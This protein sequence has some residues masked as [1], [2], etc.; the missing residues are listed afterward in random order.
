MCDR[1]LLIRTLTILFGS[2]SSTK[3]RLRRLAIYIRC[4]H[5]QFDSSGSFGNIKRYSDHRTAFLSSFSALRTSELS[6]CSQCVYGTAQERQKLD[7]GLLN[8]ILCHHNLKILRF[9]HKSDTQKGNTLLVQINSVLIPLT[10]GDLRTII[11]GLPCL[12]ILEAASAE[13]NIVSFL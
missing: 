9:Y 5:K 4:I 8:A 10:I 6:C 3:H 2:L 1:V 13:S 12:E 7:H 11:Q